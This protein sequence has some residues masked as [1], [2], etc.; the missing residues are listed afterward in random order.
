MTVGDLDRM[1]VRA[2]VDETDVPLV[3]PGQPARVYLQADQRDPIAGTVDRVS[4]KGKKTAEVVSF[5]TLVRVGS[6][7]ASRS[8]PG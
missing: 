5:E 4:P 8:A 7:R 1:Q 2:D 6:G 3:R